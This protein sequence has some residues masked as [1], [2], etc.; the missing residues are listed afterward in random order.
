MDVG[1]L[2]TTLTNAANPEF[3]TT[4]FNEAFPGLVDYYGADLPVD[5]EISITELG[6]IGVSAADSEMSGAG[7]VDLKM[8]VHTTDGTIEMALEMEATDTQ[9]AFSAAVSDMDIFLNISRINSSKIVVDSC[10]FADPSAL[11]I[12][13]ELNNL[14]RYALAKLNPY[15]AENPIVVPKNIAG[16]FELSNL[17]LGYYDDYVFV[18]ATPTFLPP[19]FTEFLQ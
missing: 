12:K 2:D 14:A 6:Q 13:L 17:Y 15:L 3:T 7:T 4:L 8:Y 16:I 10:T 18:G 19:T 9:F 5:I 1:N 11:K